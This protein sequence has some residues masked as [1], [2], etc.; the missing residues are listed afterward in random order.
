MISSIRMSAWLLWFSVAA[1]G[2]GPQTA[3]FW[4]AGQFTAL[5]PLAG[6][7]ESQAYAINERAEVVG[8]SFSNNDINTARATLWKG[9]TPTDLGVPTGFVSCSAHAINNQ[10]Q[11]AGTCYQAGGTNNHAILW[12]GAARPL[13]LGVVSGF[14]ASEA[15]GINDRGQIVG[16]LRSSVPGIYHAFL[17]RQGSMTDIGS[18][19][20]YGINNAD[21]IVGYQNA[22]WQQGV[23]RDPG[24]S[25]Y[26]INNAGLMAGF[27]IAGDVT[28]AATGNGSSVSDLGTLPGYAASAWAINASGEV[29]GVATSNTSEVALLWKRGSLTIIGGLPGDDIS[30]AQGINNRG[31]VVGVSWSSNAGVMMS[32][33]RRTNN[34]LNVDWTPFTTASPRQNATSYEAQIAANKLISAPSRSILQ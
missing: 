31:D 22:F 25:P 11:V 18:F 29:A 7:T 12:N 19:W 13:D 15:L 3:F 16:R 6:L 4:R 28:H 1:F 30:V 26:A 8:Q 9:T 27:I 23:L 33:R 21:Q 20:A 5:P 24:L 10:G 34:L 2:Q 14:L 17:W 32:T